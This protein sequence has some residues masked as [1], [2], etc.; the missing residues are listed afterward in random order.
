MPDILGPDGR[1]LQRPPTG[2]ANRNWYA[3]T[4]SIASGIWGSLLV[5]PDSLKWY[6]YQ[7]MG[8]DETV[9]FGL[10]F[11]RLAVL[12]RLKEYTHPKKSVEKFV[13]KNFEQ[14]RGALPKAA[15]RILSSLQYG[16]S[17]TEIVWRNDGARLVLDSLQTLHPSSV[18]F[19]LDMRE[20]SPTKNDARWIIQ[21]AYQSQQVDLTASPHKVIHH[22]HD[23]DFGNPYGESHVK[24][25]FPAWFVKKTLRLAWGRTL[26][27]YGS[28]WAIANIAQPDQMVTDPDTGEEIRYDEY[29]L[30]LLEELTGD[31]NTLATD[32]DTKISLVQSQRPL[33]GDFQGAEEH[34]NKMILRALLVPGLLAD[35]GNV[36]SY[37]LGQQHFDIFVLFLEDI[38]ADLIDTL[39]E[40]LVRPMVTLNFGEQ[41]EYG[42]FSTQTFS[43][44]DLKLWADIYTELTTAGYLSPA[45]QADVEMIREKIGA[46]AVEEGDPLLAA[47][48]SDS[49][50]ATDPNQDPQQAEPDVPEPSKPT[51]APGAGPRRSQKMREQL[52]GAIALL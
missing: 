37:S 15:G 38:L 43:P 46:P 21:W 47:L 10:W 42:T 7:L 35:G 48:P 27:R 32:L 11:I 6:D 41:D 30:R 13:R 3:W 39:I 40:Q 2:V 49:Q 17:V 51:S 36:G 23:S 1:P 4:K 12:S 28:P 24:A 22:V 5:N 19:Q 9:K 16:N 25:A 44:E 29:M 33:G 45:R 18:K 26:E 8:R 31:R 20:D 52:R 14:M 34:F 50:T